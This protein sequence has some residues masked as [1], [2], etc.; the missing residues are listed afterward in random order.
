MLGEAF[1]LYKELISVTT[2]I[3]LGRKCVLSE[4]GPMDK[5][6]KLSSLRV[7]PTIVRAL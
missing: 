6:Q 7:E 3:S 4:Y 5:V 1:F 2:L